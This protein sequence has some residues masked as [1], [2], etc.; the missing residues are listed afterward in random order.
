MCWQIRS[1][2]CVPTPGPLY[3]HSSRVMILI[4]VDG[5]V[6]AFLRNWFQISASNPRRGMILLQLYF[7]ENK[8]SKTRIKHNPV[9]WLPKPILMLPV[10]AT[11]DAKSHLMYGESHTFQFLTGLM[12]FADKS[13]DITS[14]RIIA[15]EIIHTAIID[16][17]IDA[18]RNLAIS[19]CLYIRDK[20]DTISGKAIKWLSIPDLEMLSIVMSEAYRECA[21]KNSM[22]S[23]FEAD[24]WQASTCHH[25]R[26]C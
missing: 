14:I 4:M 13:V 8:Y 9:P 6:P 18:H 15:P 5:L 20:Y 11:T 10:T 24:I 22:T 3:G 2:P 12:R 7:L 17:W 1:V 25:A 19:H 26:R 23:I 16:Y 21:V